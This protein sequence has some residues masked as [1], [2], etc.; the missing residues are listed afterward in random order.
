MIRGW[1][2]YFKQA[3]IQKFLK[4]LDVWIRRRLRLCIWKDWKKPNRKMKNLM[5]L[6]VCKNV[7]YSWS[8]TR[9]GTWATA[10]SPILYTTITLKRLEK[11]GYLSM[12]AYYFQVSDI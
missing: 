11:R 5:R 10:C 8:R 3:K 1:I 9:M 6:G 12:E 4:K 2:N 7:A